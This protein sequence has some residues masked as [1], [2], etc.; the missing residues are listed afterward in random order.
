M[1][2]VSGEISILLLNKSRRQKQTTRQQQTIKQARTTKQKQIT[3][4]RPTTKQAQNRLNPVDIDVLV[5]FIKVR[6]PEATC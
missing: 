6:W 2:K 4:L 5:T 1:F 3:R